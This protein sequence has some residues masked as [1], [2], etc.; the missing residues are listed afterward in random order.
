MRTSY[1]F[2]RRRGMMLMIASLAMLFIG[3]SG[4][5]MAQLCSPC[6]AGGTYR[7]T[8]GPTWHVRLSNAS[9][10]VDVQNL[11][12][13]NVTTQ[14]TSNMVNGQTYTKNFPIGTDNYGITNMTLT[15]DAGTIYG[16]YCD[17]SGYVTYPIGNPTL[18][19]RVTVTAGPS[20]HCY[21]INLNA[22]PPVG[23]V[24]PTP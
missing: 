16:I 5:A 4:A 12:T 10:S 3:M 14:V 1:L 8:I 18:C 19:V 9:L 6:A 7:I 20:P 24:C 22:V 15:T 21:T 23:G 11:R 2:T 13:G 17:P